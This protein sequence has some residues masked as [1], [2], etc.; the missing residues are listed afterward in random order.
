METT[1]TH[2]ALMW[3]SD[4]PD[5]AARKALHQLPV[6]LWR[7]GLRRLLGRGRGGTLMLTTFGRRSGRPR[8]T[9][10]SLRTID[11][12]LYAWCPYGDRADW[13]QN[14]IANPIVTVQT[15]EGTRTARAVLATDPDEVRAIYRLIDSEGRDGMLEYYL[16]RAGLGHSVEA[17]VAAG[18]GMHALRLDPVDSPGPAP[19]PED[20]TWLWT[21][22][23]LLVMTLLL[24]RR[25]RAPV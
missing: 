2:K 21:V 24:R 3:A 1:R 20:L 8:H 18:R 23:A 25:R 16:D 9:P 11:D 12:R 17:V 22:P 13:Y 19:V 14:A 4:Y 7:M 10:I 15:A 6:P 5:V